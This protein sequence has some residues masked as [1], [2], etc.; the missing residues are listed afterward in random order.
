MSDDIN[1]LAAKR[2]NKIERNSEANILDLLRAAIHD[3]ESGELKCDGL[4]L[5]FA[6]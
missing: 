5:I 3:I 6:D 4:I 1:K 2:I